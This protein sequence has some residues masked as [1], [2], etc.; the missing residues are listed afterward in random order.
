MRA[1][2]PRQVPGHVTAS[3]P[4]GPR[5][6]VRRIYPSPLD[7]YY[8]WEVLVASEARLRARTGNTGAGC[9]WIRLS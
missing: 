5:L 7:I 1:G 4:A 6:P 2:A 9:A 3:G 8:G